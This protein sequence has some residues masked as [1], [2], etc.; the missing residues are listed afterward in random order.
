MKR[1]RGILGYKEND[2]DN[3]INSWSDVKQ[4][5]NDLEKRMRKQKLLMQSLHDMVT[6]QH[7]LL[8]ALAKPTQSI[9]GTYNSYMGDV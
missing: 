5:C 1:C 8:N 2:T 4:Q 7:R 6:Q 3:N 9:S